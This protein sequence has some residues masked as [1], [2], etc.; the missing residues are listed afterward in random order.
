MLH[1]G[2]HWQGE[3]QGWQE[4]SLTRVAPPTGYFALEELAQRDS[5]TVSGGFREV[6]R[7]GHDTPHRRGTGFGLHERFHKPRTPGP[8]QGHGKVVHAV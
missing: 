5:P 3:F 7:G 2:G 1:R 4:C 6:V 8:G